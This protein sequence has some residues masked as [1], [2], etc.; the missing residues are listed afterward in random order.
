MK[1]LL[2]VIITLSMCLP[3]VAQHITEEQ[4]LQKAQAF[5][6]SKVIN[7]ANGQKGTPAKPRAMKRVAQATES[8]A[9]Y[10]FN[11]E[12][13]GGY[14][15]V[16]GDERTE[17][18]LG[19]STEGSIDPQNMP[20]NMRAW[21][22]GY[23]EQI[24]AIPS[25]A[26]AA[27]AKIPTHP[28]I[29]PMITAK[30]GQKAPYN[31][32]CPTK[33]SE[34]GQPVHCVT[35]CLA[36]AMAQIMY[37][38]QWPQSPTTTVPAY[39][40]GG[41][42]Y[43]S[44]PSTTFK[45]D[46]MKDSYYS[47]ETDETAIAISELMRYCGQAIAM[48][49]DTL[50]SGAYGHD[51]PMPIIDYFG[52]DKGAVHVERGNYSIVG[53]DQ[54]IYGE[55]SAERPVLYSGVDGDFGHAFVCDGYDGD[56][57]YHINWGWD[58]L[59]GYYLLHE[60]YYWPWTSI[61]FFTEQNAATIGIQKPSSKEVPLILTT[62]YISIIDESTLSSAF[63]N[64]YYGK[65]PCIDT[66]FGMVNDDG[67]VTE[68]VVAAENE[69]IPSLQPAVGKG[70]CNT[71]KL[72]FLMDMSSVTNLE[73]GI[74]HI[75]PIYR[76]SG[77]T[78]WQACGNAATCYVIAE[79]NNDALSFKEAPQATLTASIDVISE[80]CARGGN[81]ALPLTTEFKV[82]FHCEGNDF[83]DAVWFYDVLPDGT[84][85]R[86]WFPEYIAVPAGEDYDY[87]LKWGY[88]E[89]GLHQL[90]VTYQGVELACNS[91][92]VAEKPAENIFIQYGVIKLGSNAN[93]SFTLMNREEDKAYDGKIRM[94]L[95]SNNDDEDGER[96]FETNIHL[97]QGETKDFEMDL[98]ELHMVDNVYVKVYYTWGD[99]WLTYWEAPLIACGEYSNGHWFERSS[100]VT[101]VDNNND[102]QLGCS[103]ID[104]EHNDAIITHSIGKNEHDIVIPSKVKNPDNGKEYEIWSVTG[105]VN[106]YGKSVIIQEGIKSLYMVPAVR[107]FSTITIPASMEYVRGWALGT[108]T[109][110]EKIYCK[111]TTPPNT[112]GASLIYHEDENGDYVE[113]DWENEQSILYVPTGCAEAYRNASGW[114]CFRHIVEMDVKD[115]PST[116]NI[117][118][119]P[120]DINGDGVVDVSDYIGVA[121]HILGQ[122]QVGF[123]EQAADVNGDG[124]I[125]VSD[126]IGVANIILTGSPYGN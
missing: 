40:Y 84:V 1:K 33:T 103:V 9:L 50:E 101:S 96:T 116:T 35:G 4:A 126:Y 86:H 12:D 59:D 107:N 61:Y 93:Y 17:A 15:I 47:D 57:M 120:G 27:P 88:N 32:M 106:C 30:W 28:A 56:G 66:G 3:I 13:N 53:W 69:T 78:E 72:D 46:K 43:E 22:E 20:E 5:I 23:E 8:S 77:T 117:D 92:M 29:E 121:N 100:F 24:K 42:S 122:T 37:Y 85:E 44:L 111:P 38:H 19:Y 49:Y 48:Q 39:E 118:E 70:Y 68:I 95:V 7:N 73:D 123:N 62:S 119:T 81:S 97:E 82:T 67:S 90:Y 21:L 113:T 89:P 65:S 60:L 98:D 94:V 104:D 125:D 108:T 51:V 112:I 99:L 6:Q 110:I 91:V 45:W 79:K 16:S 63:F 124:V 52:Y 55:I 2:S 109:T 41:S 25:N 14:V 26:K 76:L 87:I 114:N 10:M 18:I 71:A 83:W 115:M 31:L 80:G 105:P 11:V 36:T 64:P 74:Y 102:Y 34:D 58:G 54:L 75:V